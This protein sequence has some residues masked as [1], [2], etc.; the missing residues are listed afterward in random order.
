MLVCGTL[1]GSQKKTEKKMRVA[2]VAFLFY[3]NNAHKAKLK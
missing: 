2:P 3:L 1:V